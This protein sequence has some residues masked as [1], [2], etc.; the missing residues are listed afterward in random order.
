MSSGM[1]V[2]INTVLHF[3]YW[4]GL[5]PMVHRYV[6]GCEACQ[7][8]KPPNHKPYGLLQS[9]DIPEERWKRINIDFVTKLPTK[10]KGNDTIITFIDGLTKRS[11]WVATTE[12]TLTAKKFAYICRY[13]LLQILW[14]LRYFSFFY[15]RGQSPKRKPGSEKEEFQSVNQPSQITTAMSTMQT[16]LPNNTN[17]METV[18]PSASNVSGETD[19]PTDSGFLGDPLAPEIFA[20]VV[21]ELVDKLLIELDDYAKEHKLTTDDIV[22]LARKS[23]SQIVFKLTDETLTPADCRRLS[24]EFSTAQTQAELESMERIPTMATEHRRVSGREDWIVRVDKE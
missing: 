12:K 15:E 2:W 4:K 22:D 5:R 1:S 24:R 18:N 7:R 20:S 19:Q 9:L 13:T 23:S 14:R 8:A 17:N 16:A 11:H 21:S 6:Q 3:I 10:E